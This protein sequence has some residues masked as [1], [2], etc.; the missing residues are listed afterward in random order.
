MEVLHPTA[1]LAEPNKCIICDE[2]PHPSEQRVIDTGQTM[3][4]PFSDNVWTKYVCEKCGLTIA[5]RLGFVS[6]E[7]AKKAFHAAEA[8][9]N[10]LA[11]VRDKVL[12]AAEDIHSYATDISLGTE[13]AAVSKWVEGE[14]VEPKATAS[15][16]KPVG[17]P[18]KAAPVGSGSASE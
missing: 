16:K 6:N 1:L 14:Y 15:E 5:N 3:I 4:A 7:Q 11:V 18:R 9:A 2:T 12:S 13:R 17:R 10:R 8:A